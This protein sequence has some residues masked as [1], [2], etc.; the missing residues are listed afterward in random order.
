MKKLILFALL[1]PSISH[2]SECMHHWNPDAWHGQGLAIVL[3]RNSGGVVPAG[4]E[5]TRPMSS[6]A[7]HTDNGEHVLDM[8]EHDNTD[9]GRQIFT[10][11]FTSADE[12]FKE[13]DTIHIVCQGKNGEQYTYVIPQATVWYPDPEDYVCPDYTNYIGPDSVCVDD[14]DVDD[15]PPPSNPD[16]TAFLN[17]IYSLFFGTP[18]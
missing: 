5:E 2:A 4:N 11:Y 6:C 13:T 1:V 14:H 9:H 16:N 10:D 18:K 7:V 17:S 3:C 15:P 12:L 8:R